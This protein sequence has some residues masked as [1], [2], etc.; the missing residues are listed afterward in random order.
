MRYFARINV[1]FGFRKKDIRKNIRM[2]KIGL[3][4]LLFTLTIACDDGDIIVTT[5]DFEDANLKSCAGPDSYV[6]FKLNNDVRETISLRIDATAEELFLATDTLVFQLNG[7]TNF[8][9]Y[10]RYDGEI[11]ESYFCNVVPPTQPEITED[12]LAASGIA[13]LYVEAILNDNDNLAIEDEGE[14]DL[15]TDGDGLPNFYD[16]DDDGD[17]VP[18]A[19]ELDTE[20]A[21][22]DNNPLTNPLDTDGDGIP[23]YLDSDDDGDGVLTR[24]EDLDG[25]LDPTNDRTQPEIGPNY[26]NPNVTEEFLV[27]KYRVHEYSINTN[28]TLFLNDVVFGNGDEEITQESLPL[29]DSANILTGTFSVIPDFEN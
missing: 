3:I 13:T 1:G 10:R 27:Q 4:L 24:N 18:T 28:V 23:D 7:T 20:N 6:F 12:Y 16:F 9:N 17:N 21:D 11:T 8:A 19:A 14:S 5:F 29:G 26:L 22:G 15:D 25:N 2:K